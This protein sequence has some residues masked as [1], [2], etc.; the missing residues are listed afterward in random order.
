MRLKE[1]SANISKHILGDTVIEQQESLKK[2]I[3][4]IGD[5]HGRSKQLLE[6]TERVLV[7]RV[8]ASQI[9]DYKIEHRSSN[10][11]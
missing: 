5:L 8:Y 7:H 11:D 1:S 4:L 10:T 2:N 6:I 9:S 3:A